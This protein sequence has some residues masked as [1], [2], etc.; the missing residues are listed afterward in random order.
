MKKA[1][2]IAASVALA[3]APVSVLA[4]SSTD[5]GNNYHYDPCA[6]SN[7]ALAGKG[8]LYYVNGMIVTANGDGTFTTPAGNI[9]DANGKLVGT[10]NG[11]A[12]GTASTAARAGVPNTGDTDNTLYYV[13]MGGA[14]VVMAGAGYVLA[15]N[16][17]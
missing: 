16:R 6:T 12:A 17:N 10:V 9:F 11:G 15:T 14:L 13:M 7:P 3:A 2:A 8:C 4:A 1:L 5:T